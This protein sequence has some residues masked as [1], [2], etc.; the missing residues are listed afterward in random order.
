MTHMCVEAAV[1]GAG[2]LGFRGKKFD[3]KCS[4]C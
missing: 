3:E 4:T 2:D 1:R